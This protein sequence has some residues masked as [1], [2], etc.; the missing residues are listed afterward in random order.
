MT[1]SCMFD[2]CRPLGLT[3]PQT[4]LIRGPKLLGLSAASDSPLPLLLLRHHTLRLF[5]VGF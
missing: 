2:W 4:C 3:M 1:L 5:S